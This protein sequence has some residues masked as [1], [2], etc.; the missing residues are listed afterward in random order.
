MATPI[1][2]IY[3]SFMT[4]RFSVLKEHWKKNAVLKN[5]G[6]LGTNKEIGREVDLG[7][8]FIEFDWKNKKIVNSVEMKSPSGMA[9]CGANLAVASMRE[10][11]IYIFEKQNL[12]IVGEINHPLFNDL[13]S[14]TLTDKK[15]LL[16]VA[17]GLD[18]ILEI[19]QEGELLWR[20]TAFENGYTTDQYGETRNLDMTGNTDYRV[21]D[22][23]T[24]QQTTHVNSAISNN[25]FVFATLFHQ[26]Q[27]IR[28]QKTTGEITVLLGGLKNPHAVR[29]LSDEKLMLSDTGTGDI[30][31]VP[32]EGGEPERMN[33]ETKWLQDSIAK[34]ESTY[35]AAKTDE[36]EIVE[37]DQIE[38]RQI[39]SYSFNPEWRF[40]GFEFKEA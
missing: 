40:Y 26:G 24:L 23:P 17:T 6:R 37:F 32:I 5:T 28:I 8:I 29:F 20:W 27:L 16:V 30:V 1:E 21:I 36:N 25:N 3:L 13:H 18:S 33:V 4:T 39:S 7:G 15:T 19:S 2:H 10:N 31:I 38:G 35:L 11:K 22:F 34:N 14:I 9:D 12:K